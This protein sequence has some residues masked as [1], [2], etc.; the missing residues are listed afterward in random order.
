[1]KKILIYLLAL[2]VIFEEWLWDLLADLGQY[3]SHILHFEKLDTWLINA[4]PKQALFSFA[5]PI[6]VVTPFNI[7]AVVLLTHGAIV[8]GVLLEIVI[9]LTGTLFIARIFR[10]VKPALLTFERFKFVYDKVVYLLRWA[11]EL[12]I[13]TAIYQFSIRLKVEIKK[14][15]SEFLSH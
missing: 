8:Q 5:I 6:I 14:K 7:L 2:F 1:M 12:V 9:K 4:S 13:Q 15:V 10:L 11:K 3:F